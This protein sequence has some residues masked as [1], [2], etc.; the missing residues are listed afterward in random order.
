MLRRGKA[1][2]VLHVRHRKN[3]R[4]I[5]IKLYKQIPLIDGHASKRKRPQAAVVDTDHSTDKY[6][7]L[8]STHTLLTTDENTQ[9]VAQVPVLTEEAVEKAA[10]ASTNTPATAS[11]P[12]AIPPPLSSPSPPRPP[13]SS[14]SPSQAFRLHVFSASRIS[15]LS[16]RLRSEALA[17]AVSALALPC[18][19]RDPSLHVKNASFTRPWAAREIRERARDLSLDEARASPRQL[20]KTSCNRRRLDLFVGGNGRGGGRGIR[21]SGRGKED[22]RGHAEQSAGGR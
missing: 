9:P 17:S 16:D 2:F 13:P 5:I 12:S 11:N 8:R 1:S 4:E 20:P 3:I 14:P 19:F 18:A 21:T 22:K 10:A 15:A 6:T 7:S